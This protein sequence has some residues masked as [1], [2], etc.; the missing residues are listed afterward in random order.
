MPTV[1]ESSEGATV[2]LDDADRVGG[3]QSGI[4]ADRDVAQRIA[5]PVS[6]NSPPVVKS[7]SVFWDAV[8]PV[9][10]R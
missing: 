7:C 10:L 3:A 6:E 5:P 2:W 8:W 4:A 9:S 1:V